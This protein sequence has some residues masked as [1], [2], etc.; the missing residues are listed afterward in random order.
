M[1]R[2]PAQPPLP[3]LGEPGGALALRPLFSVA[4]AG[5]RGVLHLCV[6]SQ[7]SAL[8]YLLAVLRFTL[9]P[10]SWPLLALSAG[11]ALP[12]AEGAEFSSIFA[13]QTNTLFSPMDPGRAKGCFPVRLSAL[14]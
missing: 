13:M 7:L 2:P 3:A 9:G 8:T 5:V 12:A 6:L 11:S 14:P 10:A 1:Q 4:V